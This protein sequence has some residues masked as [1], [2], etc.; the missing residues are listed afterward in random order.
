MAMP[1]YRDYTQRG[2]EPGSVIVIGTYG[3]TEARNAAGEFLGAERV[4]QVVHANAPRPAAA[5]QAAVIEAVQRF[6][7]QTPQEDDGTLV[8]VKLG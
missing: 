6:R 7:G 4:R 2:W 1:E 3:I 8:V 5:I